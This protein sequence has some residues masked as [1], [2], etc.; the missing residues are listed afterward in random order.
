LWASAATR[1][2][3]GPQAPP[4]ITDSGPCASLAGSAAI[5]GLGTPLAAVASGSASEA[6]RHT[7]AAAAAD[8][9][10]IAA[11]APIALAADLRAAVNAIKSLEKDKPTP[12]SL[13]TLSGAFAD[14]DTEVRTTCHFPLR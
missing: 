9:R 7:V 12:K 1:P 4:A 2:S 6:D 14:L 5:A 10:D 8:M 11:V 13:N 3:G